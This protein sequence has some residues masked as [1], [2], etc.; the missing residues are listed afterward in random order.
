MI[1]ENGTRWNFHKGA[2]DQPSQSA[3]WLDA[4]RVRL[5]EYPYFPLAAWDYAD[6]TKWEKGLTSISYDVVQ[7]ITRKYTD[8]SQDTEP[9]EAGCAWRFPPSVAENFVVSPGRDTG[10]RIDLVSATRTAASAIDDVFNYRDE[11]GTPRKADAWNRAWLLC[12]HVVSLL[13]IEALLFGLR[14]ARPQ[15]GADV[16]NALCAK[17]PIVPVPQGENSPPKEAKTG[18]VSLDAHI[19]SSGAGADN[20]TPTVLMRSTESTNPAYVDPY[21]RNTTVPFWELQVGD[22][23]RFLNSPVFS[24]MSAGTSAWG[25]ENAVVSQL[26]PQPDFGPNRLA[27]AGS[28][29]KFIGHG[30]DE[31]TYS[32]MRRKLGRF[33]ALGLAT[34]FRII[35]DNTSEDHLQIPAM[36]NLKL[37]RWAPY[38]DLVT[39]RI[40]KNLGLDDN[41][42]YDTLIS[43]PWWIL[44][45]TVW[46][47]NDVLATLNA[48]PHSI[49]KPDV[50]GLT[51]EPIPDAWLGLPPGNTVLDFFVLFPLFE[52]ALAP[53][54][55]TDMRLPL[56][57]NYFIA[58]RGSSATDLRSIDPVRDTSLVPNLFCNNRMQGTQA[59]VPV[60]QPKPHS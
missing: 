52:P 56:W 14:R 50:R 18:Y 44:M 46:Y 20:V 1:R 40:D 23:V 9:F 58:R 11:N 48:I 13:H 45:P 24:R 36:D 10:Y 25:M 32:E 27:F 15:D 17:F 59:D 38:A 4:L 39:L 54:A 43:K 53:D 2:V 31:I 37:L 42:E 6:Q 47:G 60:I 35:K 26:D 34:I 28:R 5:F 30:T 57:T 8:G 7:T 3:N 55:I 16:F 41:P 33:L 12:D 22:Q 29:A 49:G 21:F 51:L 19:P